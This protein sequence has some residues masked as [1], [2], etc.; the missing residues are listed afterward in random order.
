MNKKS[1]VSFSIVLLAV[2]FLFWDF[3]GCGKNEEKPDAMPGVKI[4]DS[5]SY[6]IPHDATFGP[7]SNTLDAIQ[8]DFD[9]F[10]WESFVALNWPAASDGLPDTTKVI[11]E[12]KDNSVVWE[13]YS[14]SYDVFRKGGLPPNPW[15]APSLIPNACKDSLN[16]AETVLQ[17]I[18]K[19][20]Q[21]VLNFSNQ[22]FNTGP[23]IDQQNGEYVRYEIRMNKEAYDYILNNKL[24]N[25]SGQAAFKN[26]V[27]FP[28]GVNTSDTVGGIVLKA[29]WKVLE[30]GVDN[31]DRYHKVK[32]L[33][34]TPAS[35]TPAVR[36]TCFVKTMG[37][38]GFHIAHKT[39][40]A[41][42]W[43]W[44]TFEQVDNVKVGPNAPAGTK[45]NFYNPDCTTCPVNTPP[46]QPWQPNKIYPV[47]ERSQIKRIIPIDSATTALNTKWQNRLKS[48]N[49]NS[50]WQYYELISTQWPTQPQN[51]PTGPNPMGNPAPEFLGNSTLETYIQGRVPNVS[52]SCIGCHNNATTT[53][54]KFSD[55]SYLL[56]QAH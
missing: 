34:Y 2:S 37:L 23:L 7:N 32:A 36:E 43:V 26:L 9:E 3:T 56:E 52:S 35:T 29:A 33:I 17:M 11:G 50:V 18:Q 46:V 49:P 20:S 16:G 39:Q 30:E 48:V 21:E 55:F 24:Y 31:F 8:H 1:V 4:N 25:K 10:S 19:V 40:S 12:N 15:G 5:L 27:D 47:N 14:S 38:V 42:Q 51:S 22:P 45:P 44:S 41:P 54:A 6:K 28:T 13:T 53:N